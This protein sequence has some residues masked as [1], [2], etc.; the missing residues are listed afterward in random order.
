[1][2]VDD[3]VIVNCTLM[4]LFGKTPLNSIYDSPPIVVT[5]KGQAKR[6]SDDAFDFE[7]TLNSHTDEEWRDIFCTAHELRCVSFSGPV[8]MIRCP[9][10]ALRDLYDKTRAQIDNTNRTYAKRRDEWI[11]AVQRRDAQTAVRE[12]QKAVEDSSVPNSFSEF[13]I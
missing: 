2:N 11:V 8:M 13:K 6:A 9:E 1:M 4:K 12:K 5:G 7:F 3:L 10:S